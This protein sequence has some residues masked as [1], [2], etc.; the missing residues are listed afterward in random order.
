MDTEVCRVAINC[1]VYEYGRW[2]EGEGREEIRYPI[3]ILV[4]F[5]KYLSTSVE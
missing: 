2:K 5:F 1:S 3:F 4:K